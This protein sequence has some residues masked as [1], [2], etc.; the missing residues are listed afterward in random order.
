MGR[1]ERGGGADR[2]VCV[3]LCLA[4][5]HEAVS[6][7]ESCMIR[8]DVGANVLNRCLDAGLHDLGGIDLEGQKIESVEGEE[9]HVSDG[10][11]NGCQ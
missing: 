10:A 2:I 1:L 8:T 7:D 5:A 3:E 6:G 9:V 4:C 11:L